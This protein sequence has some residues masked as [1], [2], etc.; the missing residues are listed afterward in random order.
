M[1]DSHKLAQQSDQ[2]TLFDENVLDT[3]TERPQ[4]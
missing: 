4:E 3:I 2:N 1:E